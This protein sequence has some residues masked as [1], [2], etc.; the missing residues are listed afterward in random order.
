ML[1]DLITRALCARNGHHWVD[2]YRTRP[3]PFK[4]GERHYCVRC[5]A[6]QM[7]LDNG[8]EVVATKR[9]VARRAAF[10]QEAA[11]YARWGA[12]PHRRTRSGEVLTW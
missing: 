10:W 7:R 2:F 9:D 1:A 8:D 3:N 5:E 12:Y 6:Q 11:Y 4:H